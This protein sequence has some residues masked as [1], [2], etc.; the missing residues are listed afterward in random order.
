[1]GGVFGREIFTI[2]GI[3]GGVLNKLDLIGF[4]NMRDNLYRSKRNFKDKISNLQ[5]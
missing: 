3:W 5:N 2:Y 4:K 1:M